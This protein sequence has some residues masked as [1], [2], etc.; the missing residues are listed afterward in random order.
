M[1]TFT[2]SG[3]QSALLL[4]SLLHK[5]SQQAQVQKEPVDPVPTPIPTDVFA[6]AQVEALAA[7]HRQPIGQPRSHHRLGKAE[8]KAMKKARRNR[9]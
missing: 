1:I 3:M 7:T 2:N 4:H 6:L 8:K 5:L 9:T